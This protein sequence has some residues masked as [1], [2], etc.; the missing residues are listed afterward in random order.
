MIRYCCS[1]CGSHSPSEEIS[2]SC[3]DCHWKCLSFRCAVWQ[4]QLR[5]L[6]SQVACLH[7][8]CCADNPF[9]ETNQ[10]TEMA[11]KKTQLCQGIFFFFFNRS[12]F[13]AVVT[14]EG[15]QEYGM[16][17]TWQCCWG[18][19][20]LETRGR[21]LSL[22]SSSLFTYFPLTFPLLLSVGLLWRYRSQR[23][24]MNTDTF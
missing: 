21:V 20:H 6:V 3:M 8:F 18:K 17:L 7:L 1:I 24:R 13:T 12:W 4:C 22:S 15:V 9:C 14:T 10:W 16:T 5:K 19:R 11:E 2:W 23:H